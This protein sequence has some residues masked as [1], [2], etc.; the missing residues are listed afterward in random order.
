MLARWLM[1]S[2]NGNSTQL[3][4]N[5][6]KI[7][8]PSGKPWL[9]NTFPASIE[10]WINAFLSKAYRK[11]RWVKLLISP[12]G[13]LMQRGRTVTGTQASTW[14]C[15]IPAVSS[16]LCSGGG[17]AKGEHLL[18]TGCLLRA[19]RLSSKPPPVRQMSSLFILQRRKSRLTQLS[20]LPQVPRPE[21][22]S[23]RP[24]EGLGSDIRVATF[25]SW[26]PCFL[27]VR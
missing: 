22:A 27:T 17:L 2:P 6:A 5:T 21:P 4:E 7:N 19:S 1:N 11:P 16:W 10:S 20:N 26:L 23:A 3:L 18:F 24:V 25:W 12:C 13:L 9:I 15:P 14:V 8:P